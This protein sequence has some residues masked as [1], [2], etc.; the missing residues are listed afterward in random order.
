MIRDLEDGRMLSVPTDGGMDGIK[1]RLGKLGPDEFAAIKRWHAGIELAPLLS[2]VGV[3]RG[4]W[5]RPARPIRLMGGDTFLGWPI[6]WHHGDEL[7]L[8]TGK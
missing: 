8:E 5:A 3:P 6:I 2:S 4:R 7:N 1:D